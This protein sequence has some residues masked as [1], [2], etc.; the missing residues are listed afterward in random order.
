LRVF[1]ETYHKTVGIFWWPKTFP[2]QLLRYAPKED[3]ENLM[4]KREDK[5]NYVKALADGK[6]RGAAE[7][8]GILHQREV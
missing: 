7:G 4:Q 1:N 2:Q 3:F 6:V 5:A 8:K